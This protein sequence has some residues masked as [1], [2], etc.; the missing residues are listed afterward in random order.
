[1]NWLSFGVCAW[2]A[3]GLELSLKDALRLGPQP[4]APSFVFVLLTAI[5]MGAPGRVV[6]WS[7]L[8]M[9]VLTDL[10]TVMPVTN[11]GAAGVVVGPHA[12]AF[13]LGTQ[14][15]MTLR[16]VM[17]RRN[18]LTMGFLAMCGSAV[19]QI[20]LVAVYSLRSLYDPVVWHASSELWARLGSSVYTGVL[21]ALLALVL[22]PLSPFLGI[23]GPQQRRF[24]RRV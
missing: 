23:A 10:T 15:V 21:G 2:V 19:A 24:A 13:V 18:P 17:I 9:G 8:I 14:L 6:L 1:M 20:A 4:I 3:V 22:L 16:G 11:G 12:V 5:A 7:S